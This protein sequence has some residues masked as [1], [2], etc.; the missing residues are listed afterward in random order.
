MRSTVPWTYKNAPVLVATICALIALAVAGPSVGQTSAHASASVAGTIGLTAGDVVIATADGSQ[1]RASVNHDLYVGDTI[2]TSTDGELQ[3]TLED[4]GYIS[5]KPNTVFRIDSYR[6]NG[7]TDDEGLFTLVKGAVRSVTGFISK[8]NMS[9]YLIRTPTATIGVRGTDHETIHIPLEEASADETP[10]THDRVY[11]GTTV[12]TTADGIV[13]V[14]AGQAG[15]ADARRRTRPKLH[16]GM[17]RFIERRRTRH[18]AIVERHSKRAREHVERK[19]RARGKL[20]PGETIN[21]YVKRKRAERPANRP[22]PNADMHK[23]SP[24]RKRRDESMHRPLQRSDRRP[25]QGD[26]RRP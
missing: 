18:E 9:G 22:H 20:K 15:Y 19:L 25:P 24:H 13:E 12:I 14:P 7:E 3:A 16:K 1:R 11:S 26:H 6:A 23:Q 17:P 5:V 4:G 10:G 2:N 8:V 21:D